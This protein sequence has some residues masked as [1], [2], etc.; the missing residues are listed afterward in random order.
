MLKV[1]RGTSK[2]RLTGME[3]RVRMEMMRREDREEEGLRM[4]VRSAGKWRERTFF[5]S[6]SK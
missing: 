2:Q 5:P 6:N 3:G 4:E 1:I